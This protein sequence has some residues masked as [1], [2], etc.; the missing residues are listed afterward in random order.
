[1]APMGRALSIGNADLKLNFDDRYRLR[2]VYQDGSLQTYDGRE[3]APSL[4]ASRIG[5]WVEGRGGT[6]WVDE[7]GWTRRLDYVPGTAVAESVL[8]NETLGIELRIRD[9]VHPQRT[10]HVRR[11]E[12]HNLRGGDSGRVR[13]FA[14][15]RYGF[16]GNQSETTGLADGDSVVMWKNHHYVQSSGAQNRVA[17]DGSRVMTPGL[18]WREVAQ[19]NVPWR[20]RSPVENA[21]AGDLPGEVQGHGTVESVVQLQPPLDVTRAGS[22]EVA[23]LWDSY[24]HTR[25]EVQA[26]DDWISAPGQAERAVDDAVTH[27]RKVVTGSRVDTL[28]GTRHAD[29]LR[30][31]AVRSVVQVALNT[32]AQGGILASSDAGVAAEQIAHDFY[33]YVWPR[34]GALIADRLGTLG[35]TAE[36][37]RFFDFLAPVMRDGHMP[38]KLNPDGSESATW[39]GRMHGNRPDLGIQEDESAL[40]AWA[41]ARHGQR[42]GP[43]APAQHLYDSLVRPLAEFLVHYRFADTGLPR[44]SWDLWEERYGI[45]AYAV[46]TVHGGLTEAAALAEQLGHRADARR[47]HDV[48]AAMKAAFETHFIDPATGMIQRTLAAEDAHSASLAPDAT[49]D[50]SL[51][52]VHE[53]GLLDRDD[54]RV[55]RTMEA[56]GRRLAVDV[57]GLRGGIARYDGD[58]YY[59]N[60]RTPAS[61]PGNPWII[62]TM[63]QARWEAE[64]ARTADEL[65]V[66]LRRLEGVARKVGRSGALPEQ[67]DA[68]TGR[69]L[70]ASPLTW[71]HAEYL[72]TYAAVAA[73]Q[74]RLGLAPALLEA[75][76][77]IA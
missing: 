8:R 1:M 46:A 39:H 21:T 16:D 73:A 34:D 30:R 12:I 45:H 3:G 5:V 50:S 22:V 76:R 7:R 29:Q 68:V 28:T 51:H 65:A 35:R 26:L 77:A 36:A 24:G 49:L 10:V 13:L 58:P 14:S 61:V 40:V 23:Y 20:D 44:P 64:R 38:H 32:T 62:A 9:A 41:A 66:P 6:S 55:V 37:Q 59:R 17:A 56:M 47:Y 70:S 69:A 31:L 54:P 63:Q 18:D 57:P 42:L 48:A 2:D 43:G 33:H 72:S 4:V 60:A 75:G 52:G 15:H 11:L 19:L 53:F 25:D 27:W 74:R 71:S 67:Y